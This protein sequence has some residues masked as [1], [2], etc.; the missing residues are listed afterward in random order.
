[1]AFRESAYFPHL[2]YCTALM[3]TDYMTGRQQK[4]ESSEGAVGTFPTQPTSLSV[5]PEV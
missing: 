3:T 2:I 4:M 5:V 1:V